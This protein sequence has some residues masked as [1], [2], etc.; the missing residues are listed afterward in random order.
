VTNQQC[1]PLYL[2]AHGARVMNRA[3]VILFSLL[4]SRLLQWLP[5]FTQKG[6]EKSTLDLLQS[7][8]NHCGWTN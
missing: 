5:Q 3:K 4:T 7:F 8:S 2:A 1:L 6:A